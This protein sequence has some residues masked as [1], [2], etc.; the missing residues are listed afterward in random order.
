MPWGAWVAW[1]RVLADSAQEKSWPTKAQPF[2][3]L[4]LGLVR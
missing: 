3:I 2:G 4:N 1:A